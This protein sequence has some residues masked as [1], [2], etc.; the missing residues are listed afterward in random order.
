ML[1]TKRVVNYPL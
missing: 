1:D